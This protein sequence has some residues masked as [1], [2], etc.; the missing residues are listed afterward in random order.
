MTIETSDTDALAADVASVQSENA[1]LR[2]QLAEEQASVRREKLI[3]NTKA[4]LRDRIPGI[5]F[6]VIN[7]LDILEQDAV[8]D[9]KGN[10]TLRRGDEAFGSDVDAYLSRLRDE[11][12]SLFPRDDLDD[13]PRD[14]PEAYRV[15]RKRLSSVR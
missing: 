13:L 6:E 1:S 3:R 10:P 2:E 14:S 5:A 9:E 7:N 8:V 11:A 12:P 4:E 15:I